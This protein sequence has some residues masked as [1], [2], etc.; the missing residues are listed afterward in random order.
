[1]LL[2]VRDDHALTREGILARGLG[3][4]AS[5]LRL[6][7]V[8]DLIAFIRTEQYANI[9]DLVNSSAELYFKPGTLRFGSAAEARVDWD[10]PPTILLDM[11][12]R[13]LGVSAFFGLELRER[14]AAI[15]LHYISF[16]EAA[17]SADE[18]TRS[19]AAALLDAQRPDALFDEIP[20]S[21]CP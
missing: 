12:F 16:A 3:R 17:P 15:D 10:R 6:V 14:E 7:D 2:K 18:N 19:L 1:M 4:V 5:E 21:L 20:P 11:E 9:G 8:I 13:H